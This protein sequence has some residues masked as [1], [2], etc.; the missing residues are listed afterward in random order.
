MDPKID[1]FGTLNQATKMDP[2]LDVSKSA[3][4]RKWGVPKV[5]QSRTRM[6]CSDFL[7]AESDQ[8]MDPKM[9]PKIVPFLGTV[10]E[11]PK[12]IDF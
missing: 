10:F 11:V 1:H 12:S 7:W 6:Q 8:K 2:F 9:D 3:N 4:V 5:K